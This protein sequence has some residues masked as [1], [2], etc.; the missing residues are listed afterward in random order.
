MDLLTDEQ[1]GGNT[2]KSVG[3]QIL[4]QKDKHID[5]YL[6][7]K[8]INHTSINCTRIYTYQNNKISTSGNLFVITIRK[9]E[10][11]KYH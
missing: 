8:I 11:Y 2:N 6:G 9:H 10:K 4:S 7:R 1:R 5:I 3:R